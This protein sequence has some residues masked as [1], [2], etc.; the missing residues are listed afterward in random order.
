MEIRIKRVLTNDPGM[1][2]L[3][4]ADAGYEDAI[5]NAKE[6]VKSFL[7][8]G[9]AVD[10]PYE[11]KSFDLVI[12][13]NTV[14]NL[15][16]KDCVKALLE[17]ERVSQKGKFITVDAYHNDEEKRRMDMWN[18]TALTYMST[19]EWQS[20]FNEVGYTGDYYWFIP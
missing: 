18:L 3:R 20:F 19:S 8:V 7:K 10:L 6:E 13:I 11:D 16:K 4:H 5:S 12:S 2:I 1:G 17:I 14:H 15:N 9:N